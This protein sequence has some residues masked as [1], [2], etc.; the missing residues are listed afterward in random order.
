V[1]LEFSEVAGRRG[2][3]S[4]KLL[5]HQERC[6]R[7]LCCRDTRAMIGTRSYHGRFSI[8]PMRLQSTQRF[9][10]SSCSKIAA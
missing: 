8:Q 7:N 4:E 1:A 2:R 6:E 9:E 10:L 3:Y 5:P